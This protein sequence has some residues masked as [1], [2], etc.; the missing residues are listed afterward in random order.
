MSARKL[1]IRKLRASEVTFTVSVEQEDGIEVRGNAMV[2]GDDAADKALEDEILANLD[3]GFI[4][5]WCCIS[6]KASWEGITGTD[7]LG[8]CS[9]KPGSGQYVDKQVQEC[10]DAHEMRKQA[11]YALNQEVERQALKSLDMINRLKVRP[12]KSS[13]ECT[14]KVDYPSRCPKHGAPVKR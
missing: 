13:A 1:K 8:A 5:A 11:L 4:E 7:H 14:C 3:R 6:V 9:F 10:I 12:A 2:S